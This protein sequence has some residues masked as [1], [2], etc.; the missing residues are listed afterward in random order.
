MVS[1]MG[2]LPSSS[3][4]GPTFSGDTPAPTSTGKV[5]SNSLPA[6][7][8]SV[9]FST[10]A[11][12]T[13]GT[14]GF[15]KG[16]FIDGPVGLVKSL[17]TLPGAAIATVG[18]LSCSA[19]PVGAP[20]VLGGLGL[21]TGAGQ[22]WFGCKKKDPEGKKDMSLVG[23]GV[24]NILI[25]GSS[26]AAARGMFDGVLDTLKGFTS[27]GGEV[28]EEAAELVAVEV[29]FAT[30]VDG[31]NVRRQIAENTRSIDQS[32]IKPV[33]HDHRGDPIWNSGAKRYA[34][35]DEVHIDPKTGANKLSLDEESD[36]R[37]KLLTLAELQQKNPNIK[38]GKL[39]EL[40]RGA[41]GK[42]LLDYEGRPLAE[43]FV[44]Q[45]PTTG[46]NEV[47]YGNGSN[48]VPRERLKY[49]SET[50]RIMSH[51]RPVTAENLGSNE[52]LLSPGKGEPPTTSPQN[53]TTQG[54]T[55]TQKSGFFK[56]IQPGKNLQEAG[57][58]IWNGKDGDTSFAAR[59]APLAKPSLMIPNSAMLWEGKPDS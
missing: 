7:A 49:S 14:K 9:N 1:S 54:N 42:Y 4:F 47:F 8:D 19:F 18:L 17:F 32:S 15:L 10:T 58:Q 2:G 59:F 57:K 25:A 48:S 50:Q 6:S 39:T 22:I 23:Q 44:Y 13:S 37:R 36:D 16:L 11:K 31:A 51:R 24:G 28:S 3:S 30:D 33:C 12:K 43:R 34:T 35:G 29:P 26:L 20:I 52:Q 56:N 38:P 5:G 45:D 27:K 21:L 55:T 41:D 40:Y 46:H 53:T